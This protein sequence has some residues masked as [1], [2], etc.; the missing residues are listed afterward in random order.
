[1]SASR[2]STDHRSEGALRSAR[3][4]SERTLRDTASPGA[5]LLP[6]DAIDEAAQRLRV[7][8]H[9]VR[10]RI[11]EVLAAGP[12]SVTKLA[13]ELS[14]EPYVASKHLAELLK[15]GVVR[16][17]QDGNF[18]VYTLADAETL[19]AAALVCRAVVRE[20]TRLARLAAGQTPPFPA[21]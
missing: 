2:A 1:M 11:T 8:G 4:Q 16:R 19:K 17:S 7:L 21:A 18:A 14:V 9:P 12:S 13:D 15:V 20:R 3:Q 5:P 10:L 6:A